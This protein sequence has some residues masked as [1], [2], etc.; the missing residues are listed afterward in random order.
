MSVHVRR[1]A[2]T[3]SKMTT[4]NRLRKEHC[5]HASKRRERWQ[6][7]IF[8][9]GIYGGRR[10]PPY[11]SL[12][13]STFPLFHFSTFFAASAIQ[14]TT[15]VCNCHSNLGD[16]LPN[17]SGEAEDVISVT[18]TLYREHMG[19]AIHIIDANLPSGLHPAVV[20]NFQ[21]PVRRCSNDCAYSAD[22]LHHCGGSR[23]DQGRPQ[24]HD[25]RGLGSRNRIDSLLS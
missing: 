2:L 22:R 11:A 20:D 6:R 5:A 3:S 18:K 12:F 24:I 14:H 9:F 8:S 7:L 17:E 21:L 15:S 19:D 23:D 1:S 4:A 25:A 10:Q 16:R 13:F